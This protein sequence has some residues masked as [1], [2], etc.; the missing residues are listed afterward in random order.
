MSVTG[1]PAPPD[2]FA[3][4][5]GEVIRERTALEPQVVIVLG[6]G[7]GAAMTNVREEA[8]F[9]FEE[10]PGFP[11]PT[12]PGHT[13]A[14]VLGHLADVPVAVF[15]GRIHF[16]E[17]HDLSVCA[18]PIRVAQQLGAGTAILTAAAG[19][20]GEGLDTGHLVVGTDHLNFLGQSPLRGW[21]RPDGA[22]P[23]VDMVDA[24]DPVLADLAV[25]AATARGVPVSRGVYAA[26]P[27][28]MYE[29]PAEIGYL[30]SAGAAVVGMSV[31]PE[32]VPAR[33]L[34]MRV[35]G[36]FF[37]TNQVA[38]PVAHADVVRASDAMAAAVG[39]VIEDVLAKGDGWTAM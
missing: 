4:A 29:T 33:A 26:M 9:S 1:L 30:R 20:I 37:V 18:L 31:V 16:Y 25:A 22:P 19:G 13:G 35:L 17:G 3:D 7:L 2:T 28:P 21:R 12:V 8:T 34:G 10:L 5:S 11:R 32:A 23:F 38:V 24:Y 27:G 39:A 15:R 36:L 6:S 14:L